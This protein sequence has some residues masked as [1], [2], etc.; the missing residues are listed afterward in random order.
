MCRYSTFHLKCVMLLCKN[1][2]VLKSPNCLHSLRTACNFA[3]FRRCS[4]HRRR[5]LCACLYVIEG[6]VVQGVKI[7]VLERKENKTQTAVRQSASTLGIILECRA[8]NVKTNV[9][10]NHSAFPTQKMC[11]LH[12]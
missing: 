12:F 8:F 4:R 3:G 2:M 11:Y 1:G 6:C 9:I 7:A 5:L 10:K